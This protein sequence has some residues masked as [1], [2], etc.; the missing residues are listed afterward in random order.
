MS[1]FEALDMDSGPQIET[2]LGTR[3]TLTFLI[4]LYYNPDANGVRKPVEV[5]KLQQTECEI[6][7]LFSGFHCWYIRGWYRHE[8][9]G[10]EFTD[11]LV[12][13]EIDAVFTASRLE[14][15]KS[16]QRVLEIRF[17]Q[18]AVYFRFDGPVG[19]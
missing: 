6:G 17:R 5:E 11:H 15:L 19:F 13:Y 7:R 9:T 3:A 1:E 12:R 14:L 4:P 16:W 2:S 10:E 18:H 8:E